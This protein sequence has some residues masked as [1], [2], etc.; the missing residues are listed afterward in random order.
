MREIRSATCEDCGPRPRNRYVC[1]QFVN[2]YEQGYLA[3]QLAMRER[4]YT[5]VRSKTGPA[6]N[7]L[8]PLVQ[9]LMQIERELRALQPEEPK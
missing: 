3:G 1:C 6:S 4:A 5:L 7:A 8:S 2:C 9:L